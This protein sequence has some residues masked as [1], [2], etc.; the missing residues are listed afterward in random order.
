LSAASRGRASSM[1]PASSAGIPPDAMIAPARS[2][3]SEAVIA[4]AERLLE[5]FRD[6]QKAGKMAF[7]YEG[8]MVDA[9]HLARAE[10][11]LALA[12]GLGLRPHPG[13]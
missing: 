7:S 13:K 5:A 6:A 12:Q 1:D 11:T 10:A 4:A 3:G 9:P 8:E 2:G